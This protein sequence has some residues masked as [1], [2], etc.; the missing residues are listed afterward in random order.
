MLEIMQKY[1]TDNFNIYHNQPIYWG[2]LYQMCAC[3][4]ASHTPRD[5]SGMM[6][7]TF[8]VSVKMERKESIG[9][10]KGRGYLFIINYSLLI[11]TCLYII[12]SLSYQTCTVIIGFTFIKS[13]K[14]LK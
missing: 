1:T 7:V 11:Y 3:T 5:R 2:F 14:M 9:V 4:R 8:H 13:D 10:A 6:A 12:T